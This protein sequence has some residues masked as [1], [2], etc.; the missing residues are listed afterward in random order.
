M[1]NSLLNILTRPILAVLLLLLCQMNNAY[2][3]TNVRASVDRNQ[4]SSEETFTLSLVA[5]SILF[6]G[7]PD[8]SALDADFHIINK[9]QSS[10]TNIING[11][12][13]SSRQWD[14]TLVAK[15]EGTLTIPA[16]PMGKYKTRPITISVSKAAKSQQANSD[17][18]YLES[19]ITPRNAYVQQE[20]QYT[21]KIFTSVN[22]LDASLDAPEVDN[23]VVEANGEQ[24]YQTLIN[25]R[26]FQVIERR[27]S[28]YPQVSGTLSIPS[29]TLQARVEGYRPSMLD[30]GRLVVKRSGQHRVKVSPPPAEFTG[31]VWLP[32]KEVEIEESWSKDPD[33]LKVGDSVTRTININADG[34]LGSQLPALPIIDL[35]NAKLYPDQA[36]IEKGDE[37]SHWTGIRSES[38]AIIP[39]RAGDFVL[40][41][42][43]LAWWNTDTDSAEFAVLP[44]RRFTVAP[45]LANTSDG[46][47]S[48]GEIASN[49]ATDK[50]NNP[51][52]D[53]DTAKANVVDSTQ[54]Y[55]SSLLWTVIA[56][57]LLS[58]IAFAAAWWR[59]RHRPASPISA[60]ESSTQNESK[61]F[62]SL[63]RCLK[64]KAEHKELRNA[65]THWASCHFKRVM[66]L[67]EIAKAIPELEEPCRQLDAH[68]F[69]GQ[70]ITIDPSTI[71]N[72]VKKAR[73]KPAA[74]LAEPAL[75]PLYK[76]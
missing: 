64:I 69:S 20:L 29:L 24:R 22:I 40:P 48:I 55:N 71:I 74:H 68:L 56:M 33:K 42:V 9:Q 14:Y 76:S 62:K 34:L 36:K 52:A 44:E 59:G 57:L 72:A 13:N 31:S 54:A 8:V 15:R 3:E 35:Q 45:A 18:I 43:R 17:S 1:P 23:A 2:A 49:N 66:T 63:E 61:A 25:G 47:A 73:S 12:V 6:S 67:S 21:V 50:V 16:L 30:P 53:N 39:T 46:T 70:A 4:V 11:K 26:Y 41:E 5:D 37:Q 10:R 65:L 51:T 32:A 38:L 19:D 7:E 60:P 58:N 28:I 75:S 27:Y